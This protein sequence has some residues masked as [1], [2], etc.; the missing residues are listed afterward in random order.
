ML[1]ILPFTLYLVACRGNINTAGQK[2]DE[3]AAPDKTAPEIELETTELDFGFVDYGQLIP[4]S[5]TLTNLGEEDLVVESISTG[6]P[7]YVSPSNLTLQGGA[8]GRITVNVQ[9]VA[10]G[11]FDNTITIVSNDED[12]GSLTV[13]LHAAAIDDVDGDGHALIE[14]GGDDCDDTDA[15]VFPGTDEVWYNG[16]DENCDGGDDY[17]QDGD[18][19]Q[20]DAYNAD[21]Q[22]GG[23]DCQDVNTDYH[24][25]APDEP[26]DNRDTNCLGDDDWDYDGDG[27]Q[28]EQYGVGSDCDDTDP[29]V[30]RDGLEAFNGKDE[31]CDGKIDNDSKPEYADIIYSAAGTTDRTGYAV[32]TGDLDG[33]GAAEIVIASTTADTTRGTVAIFDGS[34]PSSD[35]VDYAD[36]YISGNTSSDRLGDYVTVLG[37]Y[38]GN[39]VSE[40]A[41]GGSNVNGSTGAVYL[42]DGDD[43]LRSRTTLADSIVTLTGQPSSYM[44]RGIATSIDLDGDGMDELMAMYV[45]GGV[46]AMA[47]SYGSATPNA[48]LTTSN[49]EA[50]FL[51]TGAEAAFYRNAPVGTDMDGDGYEDLL[52][53]DGVAD[54]GYSNNGAA[55]ILWG[56]QSRYGSSNGLTTNLTDVASTVLAGTSDNDYA[57]WC[58]QAGD[59]WD[60]D[61]DAEIWAYYQGEGLYIFE[62]RPRAQLSAMSTADAVVFYDWTS[63]STDAEMIRQMGD[64]SGDGY[65]DMIVF[66][67]DGSSTN[68]VSEVFVSDNRSGTIT[69]KNGRVGTLEGDSDYTNGNVGYGMS[70]FPGDIEGDGD[71]DLVVGDPDFNSSEGEAYVLL[72]RQI[73]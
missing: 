61:G 30:N 53:S 14:A 51:T 18:G 40:L 28:T 22:F 68:G 66:F 21:P 36:G 50:L 31:N 71:P 64:W 4:G 70:P 3:S 29:L 65:T 56:Q 34:S 59:D 5:V 27:Y 1:H 62:G 55:W 24:P 25:G 54:Q 11:S 57:A 23:G 52:F 6:A 32:A 44:G 20:T 10:Y 12:E 73:E 37:D 7:F 17:D 38:D 49:V 13:N 19:Y 35:D 26:Y 15:D 46:N 33:D 67:E 41:I 16:V 39:G 42:I 45:T 2:P 58:T 8:S 9:L 60:G 69:Q 47:L 43:S 72:N 63:S 48:A